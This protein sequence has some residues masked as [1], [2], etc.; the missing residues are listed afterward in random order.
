MNRFETVPDKGKV[1]ANSSQYSVESARRSPE[2]KLEEIE[3]E[4]TI[5]VQR[6]LKLQEWLSNYKRDNPTGR[7]QAT[8]HMARTKIVNEFHAIQERL[9]EINPIRGKL[10]HSLHRPQAEIME[11]IF[12]ALK[13]VISKL[14]KMESKQ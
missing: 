12:S 10:M 7:T 2:F 9:A 4:R 5:L 1:V 11:D 6:K 3:K 13:I 8:N 14:S